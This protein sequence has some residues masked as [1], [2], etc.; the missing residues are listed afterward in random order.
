[1][2]TSLVI[3]SLLILAGCGQQGGGVSVGAGSST[4]S[5][6]ESA[7]I[8]ERTRSLLSGSAAAKKISMPAAGLIAD[9]FEEY[10][11]PLD[12]DARMRFFE[13]SFKTLKALNGNGEDIFAAHSPYELDAIMGRPWAQYP[14]FLKVAET[15]KKDENGAEKVKDL[16]H[17]AE[18][19]RPIQ[20]A[21]SP[22]MGWEVSP[23]GGKQEVLD[24]YMS[25]LAASGMF[26]NNV[27]AEIALK[28]SANSIKNPDEARRLIAQA[29]EKIP[30]DTLKAEWIKA[31][32]A[33][34][35]SNKS[36]D[37]TGSNNVH[38]RA[39]AGDFVGDAHGITWTKGG[40]IWFGEGNLSGQK[41]AF[42]LESTLTSEIGKSQKTEDRSGT[43]SKDST[44]A[45]TKVG[46]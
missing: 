19:I 34:A 32:K 46:Q 13:S 6:D 16:M 30:L 24:A 7:G 27:M 1:M 41:I 25:L 44:D 39:G 2:K 9:T 3:L 29:Y 45:G 5:T 40:Q 14:A 35:K 38:F 12:R 10:A 28:Q 26:A 42:S 20:F 22:F 15:F 37:M 11:G 31:L 33:A 8:I 36:V 4:E 21:L 23:M 18:L 43:S 17:R